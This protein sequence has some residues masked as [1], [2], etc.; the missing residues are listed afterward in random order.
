MTRNTKTGVPNKKEEYP[1]KIL[2]SKSVRRMFGE[3][4]LRHQKELNDALIEVYEE[5]KI[6]DR[7]QDQQ[8]TGERFELL[9][10][11]S[12]V[13]IHNPEAVQ[14]KLKKEALEKDRKK[15][16]EEKKKKVEDDKKKKSS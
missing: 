9:R 10:D 6:L 12:G 8:A 2:F 15:A 4:T 5:T 11:F 14:E 13:T 3:I 7:V 1:I 16:L